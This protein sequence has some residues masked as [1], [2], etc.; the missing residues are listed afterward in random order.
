MQRNEGYN[1]RQREWCNLL[2][3]LIRLTQGL[4]T[5]QKDAAEA[6]LNGI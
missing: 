2:T 5:I 6:G 1:R 3:P 4:L